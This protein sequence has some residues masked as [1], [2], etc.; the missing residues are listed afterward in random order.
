MSKEPKEFG[1]TRESH[2]R[3]LQ[4]AIRQILRQ[5]CSRQNRR[6]RS[7]L[8]VHTTC[9]FRTINRRE[10]STRATSWRKPPLYTAAVDGVGGGSPHLAVPRGSAPYFWPRI[11]NMLIP[12]RWPYNHRVINSL[13]LNIAIWTKVNE[14]LILEGRTFDCRPFSYTW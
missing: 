1:K 3:R 2:H 9:P 13:S 10:E 4:V 6:R 11:L 5:N 8:A 14:D 12:P 7:K